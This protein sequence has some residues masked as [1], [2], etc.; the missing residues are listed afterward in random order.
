MTQIAAPQPAPGPGGAPADPAR[1]AARLG[2][3]HRPFDQHGMHA[4]FARART[5]APVFLSP[6]IGYWVVTR[7]EDVL[8]V[9]R[10]PRR[11]SA[12]IALAPVRP[13][14]ASVSARLRDGGYRAEA[15]RVS[16]DDP[17]HGRIRRFAGRLLSAKAFAALE[18]DIRRLV[19]ETVDRLPTRGRADMVADFA[20]ELPARVV[21]LLI[22][23]P[24]AD[25][26]K[27]KT[28]AD[29]RLPFTFGELDETAQLRAADRLL[30]YWRYCVEMVEDRKRAPR[31]DY[32][33][34]LLALRAGDDANMTENEVASLVFGLL[35]AGHETTSNMTANALQALLSHPGAWEALVADP[36]LIPNAVEECLRWHGSVVCWRRRALEDVEVGGQ[37]IP[38][39]AHLLLALASANRDEGHFPD[40]ETFDIRRPNARDHLSFG[41][42]AHF[43]LGAPLAR[44]ELR[45]ILEELAA[46]RPRLRLA[47]PPEAAPFIRT[48][49]FRGPTR[50]QVEIG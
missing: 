2:A 33:S 42:G 13:L 28:W 16:A 32:A 5:E 45:I 3:A 11:F 14:P 36:A 29:D 49:A 12:A 22:G 17:V 1:P 4:L 26:P 25:V 37:A 24:D 47:E 9:F 44:L 6:E 19:R 31:D 15:T 21:F 8:A 40:P 23:A 39:G 43:C 7:R 18:P 48:L 10:D 50:L 20:Y 46:R 35:L 41:H 27:I 34:H 30:D 38:A